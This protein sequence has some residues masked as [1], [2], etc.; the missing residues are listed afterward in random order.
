MGEYILAIDI[1]TTS[2][3]TV[4]VHC[5]TG[6]ILRGPTWQP[7]EARIEPDCPGADLQDP[8]KIFA[9]VEKCLSENVSVVSS[10]I[11]YISVCGQM[12]GVV[13]WNDRDRPWNRDDLRLDASKCSPLYTWQDQR[14]SKDFID[15][16]NRVNNSA[17]GNRVSNGYGNVTLKWLQRFRPEFLARFDRAATIMDLFIAALLDSDVIM[18]GHNAASFG[19][20][21]SGGEWNKAALGE[22]ILKMLPK[23]AANGGGCEIGRLKRDKCFG[24]PS[25]A[26]I[27]AAS[28]DMQC[29]I[30]ATLNQAENEGQTA[31]L[32]LN[33][34][35]QVAFFRPPTAAASSLTEVPYSENKRLT[36]AASLNGGNVLAA[37]VR[38]LESWMNE[39]GIE[40]GSDEIWKKIVQLEEDDDQIGRSI[41]NN[42][43]H[44]GF[45]IS[46]L[47]FGERHLDADECAKVDGIKAASSSSLAA[48]VKALC[49]GIADNLAAMADPAQMEADGIR[50]LLASGEALRLNPGLRH[51]VRRAFRNLD[52][53]FC[54]DGASC[55]GAALFT[56]DNV[57]RS[58]D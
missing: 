57:A 7:L 36:V 31:V 39:F 22:A 3:K 46:P 9:G 23:V 26:K 34:S 20:F 32:N 27:M 48:V 52:C 53:R 13:L 43:D 15:T 28:G 6:R 54:E 2:V 21:S 19:Y 41:N 40:L 35:A 37:F 51:A 5:R 1:G 24:I 8:A 11:G 14:C 47:L 10:D 56:L 44:D 25:G 55:L 4:V 45:K 18:S 42:D 33:T 17:C 50:V 29:A 30:R 58:K 49:R 16:C 38:M 12:H